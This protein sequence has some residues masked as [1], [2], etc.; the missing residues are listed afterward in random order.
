MTYIW[1]FTCFVHHLLGYG[2]FLTLLAPILTPIMPHDG[3]EKEIGQTWMPKSNCYI[4]S[5]WTFTHSEH[6]LLGDWHFFDP[7]DPHFNS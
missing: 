7:F 2:H 6:H 5:V 4:T 1:K 3:S